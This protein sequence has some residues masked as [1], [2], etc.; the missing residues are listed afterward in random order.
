VTPDR[1]APPG[2]RRAW[3]GKREPHEAAL[4]HLLARTY[5][6]APMSR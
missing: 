5:L 1:R 6:A 4:A 3:G 2:A